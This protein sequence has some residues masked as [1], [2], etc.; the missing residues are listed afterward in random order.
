MSNFAQDMRVKTAWGFTLTHWN[1][2]REHER[3]YYREYVTT[4]PNFQENR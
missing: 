4:A 2:L 1:T 3:A